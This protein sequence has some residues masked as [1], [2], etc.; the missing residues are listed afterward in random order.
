MAQYRSCDNP[1]LPF[2]MGNAL[3]AAGN[4]KAAREPLEQSLEVKQRLAKANPGSSQDQK[5]V[6]ALLEKLGD[7]LAAEGD[8]KAAL[9]R[10]AQSF[11]IMV[12]VAKAN[13]DDLPALRKVSIIVEKAGDVAPDWKLARSLFEQSLQMRLVLVKA[14]PSAEA[15]QDVSALLGKL[16]TVLM[17]AGDLK[18]AREH[19]KQSLQ[20]RQQLATANPSSIE[21]QRDL[22]VGYKNL[23]QATGE[24][25]WFRKALEIAERMS[26]AGQLPARDAQMI[27]DLRQK[28]AD[29]K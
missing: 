21:A 4:H 15:Q 5:D 10:F 22:I 19:F 16:G 23:G 9:E 17:E 26:R 24:R 25:D 6:S 7:V 18:A 29:G 28:A 2:M 14:N 20:I 8:L 3:V 1:L 12:Q 11:K 13:P 27:D